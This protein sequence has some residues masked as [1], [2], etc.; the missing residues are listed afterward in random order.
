MGKERLRFTLS[1]DWTVVVLGFLCIISILLGLKITHPS[2]GWIQPEDFSGL[3]NANN[4]SAVSI[5]FLLTLP[6]YLVGVVLMGKNWRVHAGVFAIV[7]VL[8]VFS[9]VIAGNQLLS[10]WNIEGVIVSL[11]LGLLI[12][13]T[14]KV[15]EAFTNA[16]S[17]ELLVKTGL[18]ILG[19][20]VIL[21][22]IFKAGLTG[23]LQ[24]VIVVVSVWYFSYWLCKRLKLD[25]EMSMMLSSAV[26]I[27]GVS[28]AIATAGAIKGDAKKLSFVI[29]LV[30]VTAIPMMIFMPYLAEWL[31]LSQQVTGAWFGGSIDTTGAVVASGTLVGDEALKYSTIVKFSQNVLLGLAA[32]G[33][34]IYWSFNGKN[35]S[36]ETQN[37]NKGLATIWQRFPKFVIGFLLASLVF[38][39]LLSPEQISQYKGSLKATQNLWFALA[40]T[41]IGLETKFSQIFNH[42]SRK[43]LFAFLVAQTFNVLITLLIAV[44]LFE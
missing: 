41:S 38:S 20:S 44:L 15:P 31:G 13:N 12:S 10:D 23:M 36:D 26:S 42:E 43:P 28:A 30:L 9:A 6:V 37:G 39:L 40:F 5:Q 4:F 21:G 17:S 25:Q 18:V 22:D 11:V 27:C 3:L 32:L 34:S 8:S 7:F 19:S 14:F 1:E 24:S 16:L 29:S 33:I 2:F 35:N